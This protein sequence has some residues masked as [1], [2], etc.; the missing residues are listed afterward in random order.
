MRR[1]LV[2]LVVA[3]AACTGGGNGEPGPDPTTTSS[4]DPSTTTTT[5]TAPAEARLEWLGGDRPARL[6]IPPQWDLSGPT[7]P[8][9]VLLH[10]YGANGQLQ[11]V[12]LGISPRGEDL[13]YLTLT[14]D[15]TT[16]PTGNR[17]WNVTGST[18]PV[19]DVAYLESL[20][21][22]ATSG[23][24]VDPNRVYVVGHSNG[25][26]M[27]HKLACEIPH[28][29]TRVAAIAGGIFGLG[30]GCEQPVPVI[31]V[32][33]TDDA[34]VPYE[35]GVFLGGR[36]LGAEDTVARW[37]E[38]GGC[39]EAVVAEGPY[40]FDLLVSGEET[41]IQAWRDCTEPATVE[42]WVMEGSG[43]IPGFRPA[44]RS[45][46]MQRLLELG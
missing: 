12:Y 34:T 44:F 36:I 4:P 42:L 26:Y 7:W 29:I 45:A 41:S 8:L 3:L 39:S 46:L 38:L 2:A 9:V 6:V 18:W 13:G 30:A 24:N 22:E 19:D 32:Q 25:G 15:G 35:G 10:G 37:R 28:R 1:A 16:D 17:F 27:A 43:H 33:G 11:D 23:F 21:L 14:P 31:M 5:T 20:I 40:D